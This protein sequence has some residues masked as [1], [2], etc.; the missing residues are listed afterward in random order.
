MKIPDIRSSIAVVYKKRSV[1]FAVFSTVIT[2]ILTKTNRMILIGDTNINI[3]NNNNHTTQYLTLIESLG[4]HSLNSSDKIYATRVN[5]HSNA[6]HTISSTLDHIITNNYSFKFNVRINDSHF[7]DHKQIFL[8]FR[9]TSNTVSKFAQKSQTIS[10]E[11]L[12]LE[13][14]KSIVRREINTYKPSN[15]DVLLQC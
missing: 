3:Q 1:S 15:F 12:N 11:K 9:N 2:K 4:C 13:M 7:S 5:N 8:S 14:F 10:N 6:R